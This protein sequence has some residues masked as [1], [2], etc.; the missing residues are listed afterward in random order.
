MEVLPH[1]PK[2]DGGAQLSVPDFETLFTRVF[3]ECVEHGPPC[4]S[5]STVEQKEKCPCHAKDS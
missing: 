3:Y 5:N 2:H 4:A 1:K